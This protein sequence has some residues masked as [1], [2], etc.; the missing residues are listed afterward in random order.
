MSE[1]SEMRREGLGQPELSRKNRC[2][3]GVF[4]YG[5]CA[6]CKAEFLELEAKKQTA[7]F[8]PVIHRCEKHHRDYVSP[9]GCP[10]CSTGLPALESVIHIAGEVG[11][12]TLEEVAREFDPNGKKASQLGDCLDE[13]K[14][15]ICGERQ[16]VYGSPEDSFAIIAQ[17][18][19]TYLA[20]RQ[21][22]L[23]APLDSKDVA[24]MM[25]LFKMARVQGQAPK[26]D[27][28][29]DLCG[30]AAIAADR[31]SSY[32]NCSEDTKQWFE[33]RDVRKD[34]IN[35]HNK[36]VVAEAW[37]IIGKNTTPAW[38]DGSPGCPHTR[39]KFVKTT[40]GDYRQCLGCG[41]R[42]GVI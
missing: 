17:Y 6:E 4:K 42:L 39:T 23:D 3:H 28:Y 19:S 1:T 37:S 26:R 21:T 13:A 10:E 31:L 27:N 2:T 9:P 12:R 29:V 32:G 15:T 5:K 40:T 30:Y 25:V 22:D 38:K 11:N 18:W 33:E 41:A 36:K 8:P 7:S 14:K 34:R 20:A 24:H 35:E 16:D